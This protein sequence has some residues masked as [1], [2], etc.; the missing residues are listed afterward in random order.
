MF[1]FS[2]LLLLRGG[3]TMFKKILVPVDGSDFADLAAQRAVFM[4]VK[5]GGRITLLHIINTAQNNR[6]GYLRPASKNNPTHEREQEGL[7][8]LSEVKSNL[9]AI[10]A[11]DQSEKV[12]IETELAW[13]NPADVIVEKAQKG[14]FNLIV[15]GSRGLGAISGLLL[16]SVSDRVAK[17]APCP[18]LIVRGD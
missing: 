7:A 16:G 15:M 17:L 6:G 9:E 18:V 10:Q 12:C 4:A 2:Y 8:L 14:G 5:H 1:S 11:A 3:L 13:G